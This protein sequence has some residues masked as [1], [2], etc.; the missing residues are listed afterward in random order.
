MFSHRDWLLNSPM[1]I[2]S[3]VLAPQS[4]KA[5]R[6]I[7]SR[8]QRRRIGW[9]TSAH[10]LRVFRTSR[11]LSEN[12][13]RAVDSDLE[14]VL[15]FCLRLSVFGFFYCRKNPKSPTKLR[16]SIFGINHL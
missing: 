3:V 7:K 12:C 4:W 10:V 1:L 14:A 5:L 15:Q 8:S 11:P 2:A 16:C 9:T 13:V 6:H